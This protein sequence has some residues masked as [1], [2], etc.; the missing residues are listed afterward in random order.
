MSKHSRG[1]EGSAAQKTWDQFTEED[2]LENQG[3]YKQKRA[4]MHTYKYIVYIDIYTNA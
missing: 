4:H 3:K 2:N 1:P